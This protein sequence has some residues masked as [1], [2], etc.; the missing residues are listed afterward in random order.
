MVTVKEKLEL[1]AKGK[2]SGADNVK[3]FLDKIKKEDKKINSFIAINENAVAEAEEVDKKLRKGFAG[4]LA[5]L[6]IAVKSCISV[7]GLLV[8]CGSKTLEN[9][10]GT[11]DAD[12]I[13]RI[14]EEGG[15]IIGMVNMDEFACGAS[16]ETSAFGAT[17]N[18]AALGRIPGGSSSGS[19]AA[20]AA[21]FCDLALG[22][23]TGGSIRNPASHCGVVGLKP[24][25]GRVSRYG[26]V[27]MSMS[28]EGIGCLSNDVYGSALMLQVIAG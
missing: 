8:T 5:G 3:A 24:S 16:G 26:L 9:Y 18:P 17:D 10:N 20:V 22:S 2:L 21:G 23:D 28:L 25:Y 12:V 27:D 13:T 1:I 19:A 4:K 15:I 11:F 7:K 6:A 14:K